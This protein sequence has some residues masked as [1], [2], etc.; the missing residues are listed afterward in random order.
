LAPEYATIDQP[1][2]HAS[3]TM[4]WLPAWLCSLCFSS[5][6]MYTSQ[7]QMHFGF[8]ME[9]WVEVARKIMS[10]AVHDSS[11]RADGR[12]SPCAMMSV[13]VQKKVMRLEAV[14]P[15]DHQQSLLAALFV[16]HQLTACVATATPFTLCC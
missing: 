13:Q 7:W 11:C 3:R 1:A 9:A 15:S 4:H 2:S 5:R 8:Y 10:V 12:T 16:N 14:F 6:G